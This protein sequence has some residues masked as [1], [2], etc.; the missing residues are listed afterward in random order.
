MPLR[1][2]RSRVESGLYKSCKVAQYLA[3]VHLADTAS[4]KKGHE[5][6][7]S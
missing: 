5:M 6:L 4:E 1:L 3:E 2:R 7:T